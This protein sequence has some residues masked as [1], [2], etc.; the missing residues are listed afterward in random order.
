MTKNQGIRNF[1]SKLTDNDVVEILSSNLSQKA[2]AL[3]YLVTQSLIS[4]IKNGKLWKHISI[5]RT[6]DE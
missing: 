4:R 5:E 3:R 1:K 2:L 6:S